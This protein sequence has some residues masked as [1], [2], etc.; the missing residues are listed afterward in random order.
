MKNNFTAYIQNLLKFKN[1][2]IFNKA[3]KSNFKFI[4]MFIILYK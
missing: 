3:G 4:E 1:I 2:I